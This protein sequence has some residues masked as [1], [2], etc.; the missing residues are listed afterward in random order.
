M[1]RLVEE[2]AGE[3]ALRVEVDVALERVV[4]RHDDVDAA[5]LLE[6]SAALRL[7][8][9][10]GHRLKRGCEA[11]NL[12][13]PVVEQRGRRDDERGR[14]LGRFPGEQ[15]CD[16]LQCLAKAHVICEDAAEMMVRKA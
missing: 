6:Q 8:S 4:R 10:H 15:E 9:R 7:R 2:D 12:L 14:R 13:D 5:R 1:L 11:G 16:D 3:A